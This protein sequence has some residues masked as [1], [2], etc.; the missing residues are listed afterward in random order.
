MNPFL[1]KAIIVKG[2]VGM[3][4]AAMGYYIFQKYRS[5]RRQMLGM[6]TGMV[7]GHTLGAAAGGVL[8]GPMGAMIGM[9]AGC[10]SGCLVGGD[11]ATGEDESCCKEESAK[12]PV[13][14]VYGKN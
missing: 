7:L 14:V 10:M 1:I 13:K 5:H 9:S 4:T 3:A 6:T 12:P 2:A 11:M 8:A